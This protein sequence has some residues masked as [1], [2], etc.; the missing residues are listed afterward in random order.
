MGTSGVMVSMFR[1]AIFASM[2]A[3]GLPMGAGAAL[4]NVLST[5]VDGAGVPLANGSPEQNFTLVSSPGAPEGISQPDLFAFVSDGS[6]KN[7]PEAWVVDP[8]E[9]TSRW[10]VPASSGTANVAPGDYVYRTSFDLTGLDASTATL[11]F[12]IAADNNVEVFLNGEAVFG[13][14]APFG[15]FASFS[16]SSGF[17]SGENTLEFEVTNTGS[18]VN[19]SGLN[20]AVTGRAD[21]LSPIP[22]PGSGFLLITG[23]GALAVTRFTRRA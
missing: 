17:E 14:G 18:N 7:V 3:V 16:V 2:L 8:I 12:S 10:I 23:I 11:S 20:V 5:G 15:S 21:E 4:I 1:T 22:L 19:P 9:A 13:P 6:G